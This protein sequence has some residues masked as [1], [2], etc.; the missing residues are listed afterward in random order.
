MNLWAKDCALRE[1]ASLYI[2]TWCVYIYRDNENMYRAHK[3]RPET[4]TVG[5]HPLCRR[6]RKCQRTAN[7][8]SVA[9][10][11]AIVTLL[12]SACGNLTAERG[13][14]DSPEFRLAISL[15]LS[16]SILP[17][18]LISWINTHRKGLLLREEG[19]NADVFR[20]NYIHVSFL[21]C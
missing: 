21:P 18:D 14:R 2:R 6:S 13:V 10:C 4:R 12:R 7:C 16:L 1:R 9:N 11:R 8:H 5:L 20:H 15:S 19:V 3:E 17:L